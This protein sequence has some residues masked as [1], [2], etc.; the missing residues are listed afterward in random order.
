MVEGVQSTRKMQSNAAMHSTDA[1]THAPCA[2]SFVCVWPGS[3]A[4]VLVQ[5]LVQVRVASTSTSNATAG[6]YE[7][8]QSMTPEWRDTPDTEALVLVHTCWR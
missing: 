6:D 2:L 1:R 5:V 7:Y 4:L 8:S 3:D